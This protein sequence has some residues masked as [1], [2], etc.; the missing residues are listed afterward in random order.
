MRKSLKIKERRL[1]KHSQ[2]RCLPVYSVGCFSGPLLFYVMPSF[3][4]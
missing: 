1:N 2:L 4:K 3:Q